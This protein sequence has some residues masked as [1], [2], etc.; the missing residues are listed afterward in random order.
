[1]LNVVARLAVGGAPAGWTDYRETAD[2][3]VAFDCCDLAAEDPAI[4]YYTSGSTG[5]PKGVRHASRALFAWRVT[6]QY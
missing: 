5:H 3:E 6:A 4:M 1:M 2:R